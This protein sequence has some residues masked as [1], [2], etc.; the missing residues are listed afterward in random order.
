M[1]V[2]RF[3]VDREGG[4]VRL[5]ALYV[6]A[7]RLFNELHVA[8][9]DGSFARR[10]TQFDKPHL[11]VL[12]DFAISP[13]GASE[14]KDLLEVLDDR[15]GTRSALITSQLPV[16]AWHTYLGEPTLADA[17]LG[18]WAA[19]HFQISVKRWRSQLPPDGSVMRLSN[20]LWELCLDGHYGFCPSISLRPS[21]LPPFCASS[22][23]DR[24][25]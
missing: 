19:E 3:W 1:E 2:Y 4:K 16:H 6:A 22:E 7:R 5:F 25:A 18:V 11:L 12:D 14:R 8:P 21:A 15:V 9:G 24:R 13:V 23:P 17:I 20:A 10:L